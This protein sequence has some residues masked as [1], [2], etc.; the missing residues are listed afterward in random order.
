MNCLLV[1]W[2]DLY[3]YLW[4]MSGMNG[5]KEKGKTCLNICRREKLSIQLDYVN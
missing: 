5:K 2:K 1:H 4:N 3:I